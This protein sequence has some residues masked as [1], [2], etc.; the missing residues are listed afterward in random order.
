[1]RFRREFHCEGGGGI[2]LRRCLANW[3]THCVLRVITWGP[4]VH[5]CALPMHILGYRFSVQS[6]IV[7]I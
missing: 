3:L 1:M 6:I 4:N 7:A 2:F 5:F